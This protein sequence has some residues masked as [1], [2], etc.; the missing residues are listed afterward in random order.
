MGQCVVWDILVANEDEDI[1]G[2]LPQS[3]KSNNKLMFD[4]TGKRIADN[5]NV[6]LSDK[7]AG[8]L[9]NELYKSD[10]RIDQQGERLETS[11]RGMAEKARAT[12]TIGN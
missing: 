10:V 3:F 1:W 9:E 6:K 7:F 4:C 11:S 2:N 8:T 5:F 12:R